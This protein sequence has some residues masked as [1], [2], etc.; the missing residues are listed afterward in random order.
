MNPTTNPI[1]SII[2][3]MDGMMTIEQKQEIH[4]MTKGLTKDMSYKNKKSMIDTCIK[5][6][7]DYKLTVIDS[8]GNTVSNPTTQQ[9]VNSAREFLDSF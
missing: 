2:T 9:K 3:L 8:T 4:N 7:D 1:T 6:F 5:T